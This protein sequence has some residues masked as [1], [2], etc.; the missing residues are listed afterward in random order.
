MFGS[1]R[2]ALVLG[3]LT[4]TARLSA[5]DP[6]P[7]DTARADEMI[8]RYL[9]AETKKLSG[10]FM[11][12]AKSK[13]EWEAKRPRLKQEFLDML[14]L[15]PL[16]EKTDLK[17]T[18]TGT[19]DRG[20]VVIENLHYQSR[21]GLYVTGNLYRPKANY[22]KYPAI[23]YVCGHSNKGRDG[24]KTADYPLTADGASYLKP[25]GKWYGKFRDAAGRVRRV[26]L[27][28]NKD[29]ARQMLAGLVRK[30]EMEKAGLRDPAAD[31]RSQGR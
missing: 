31:H 11:D 28:A 8:H 30:V 10:T 18:V 17:A 20:D 7:A 19:L 29:A 22:K 15:W 4:G 5:A 6:K 3:T 27:S 21:P 23:L 2:L 26:P 12:G 1:L 25:A 9:V 14:G 24:N 13:A 16:P